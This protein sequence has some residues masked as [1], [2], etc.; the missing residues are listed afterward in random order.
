MTQ[1]KLVLANLKA[2]LAPRQVADWCDAFLNSLAAVPDNMEVI[3]ALPNMA[4]ADCAGKIRDRPGVVLAAQCVSPFPQGSYT[5]TTPAAWLRGL[6]RYTLAGHRERRQYFHET[7]QD[8]AR[9]VQEALEEE[10]RP[11]VCVE[12]GVFVQQLAALRQEEQEKVFWAFTP[13]TELPLQKDDFATI[14]SSVAAIRRQSGGRPVLYGGRVE[15]DNASA[16]WNIKD[17]SGIMLG[18][19]C[20]DARGFAGIIQSLV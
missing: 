9:E 12:S 1:K 5:G 10:I 18:R 2:C 8:V 16:V 15:A 17:I 3:L 7:V 11:I 4:L 20:H 13:R 14:A 6:V 19:A